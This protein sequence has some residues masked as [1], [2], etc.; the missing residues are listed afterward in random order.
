MSCIGVSKPY[1]YHSPNAK[2]YVGDNPLCDIVIV[3]IVISP[4]YEVTYK[5]LLC[6]QHHMH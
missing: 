4:T 5:I 3:V 1:V 6:C 2:P